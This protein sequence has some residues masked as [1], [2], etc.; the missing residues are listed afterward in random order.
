MHI[1]AAVRTGLLETPVPTPTVKPEDVTPGPYGFLIVALLAVVVVLLAIDMLRR[2]RR[3]KYRAEVQEML[4]AEEA[5][6]SESDAGADG[7][8][9]ADAEPNETGS[10]TRVERR[11][12]REQQRAGPMAEECH[13]GAHVEEL[14]E[15]EVIPARG[16]AASS[17]T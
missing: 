5:A 6:A 16:S 13:H 14:V 15:P 9:A 11:V 12:D 4:D 17:R 10:T 7:A 8:P 2:I 1:L 3:V